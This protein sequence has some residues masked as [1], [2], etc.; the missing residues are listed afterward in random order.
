MLETKSKKRK[1]AQW[2]QLMASYE[3]SDMAQRE[4]CVKHGVAYSSFCYWRKQLRTAV[5]AETEVP[6][7]VELRALASSETPAWRVELDLG[8]GMVLRVR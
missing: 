4:F 3:A 8:K 6:A 2:E 1:R 5:S 7:L